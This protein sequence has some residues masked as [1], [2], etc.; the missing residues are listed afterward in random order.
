MA[1]TNRATRVPWPPQ[2]TARGTLAIGT[3]H[4]NAWA[5]KNAMEAAIA[6]AKFELPQD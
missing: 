4:H 2:S 5:A 6:A 1:G 3:P